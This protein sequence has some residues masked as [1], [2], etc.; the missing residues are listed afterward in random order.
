LISNVPRSRSVHRLDLRTRQERD[1][2]VDDLRTEE[3]VIVRHAASDRSV[4]VRLCQ[5]SKDEIDVAIEA[6]HRSVVRVASKELQYRMND[7]TRR[8]VTSI[9]DGA[10]V[11]GDR[12]LPSTN[13]RASMRW[14]GSRVRRR[15]HLCEGSRIGQERPGIMGAIPAP[16]RGRAIAHIGR[17]VEDNA[18]ALARLVTAE[19]GKPLQ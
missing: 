12:T 18:E 2:V 7:M 4:S 8:S 10:P 16:I 13:R 3:H 19:I 6:T 14:S 17:L 1:D 15:L 11:P 5:W 9:I